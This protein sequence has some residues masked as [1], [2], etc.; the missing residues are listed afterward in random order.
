MLDRTKVASIVVINVYKRLFLFFFKKR[1][2]NVFLFFQRFLLKKTLNNQ[3]ENSS[4]LI[5][6]CQKT[7]NQTAAYKIIADFVF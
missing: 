5:H 1:V 6:L 2:F 4:N 3:C 7:E